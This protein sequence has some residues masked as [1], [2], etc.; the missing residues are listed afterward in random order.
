[1]AQG[2][3]GFKIQGWEPGKHFTVVWKGP[4]YLFT[5]CPNLSVRT[6]WKSKEKGSMAK[7][8]RK[9]TASTGKGERIDSVCYNVLDAVSRLFLLAQLC[10][11]SLYTLFSR[12]LHFKAPTVW[13]IQSTL[14]TRHRVKKQVCVLRNIQYTPHTKIKNIKVEKRESILLPCN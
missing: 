13:S 6:V 7:S 9:W 10:L 2:K 14:W 1:M 4:D 3:K 11:D 12:N 5:A 8:P